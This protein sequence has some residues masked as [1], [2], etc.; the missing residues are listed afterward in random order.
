MIVDV[1]ICEKCRVIVECTPESKDGKPTHPTKC[2]EC[3]ERMMVFKDVE[4]GV[5][6]LK[7]SLKKYA[8][9]SMTDPTSKG[10]LTILAE[11]KKRRASS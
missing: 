1:Q 2:P 5:S 6:E 8:Y 9:Y 4:T 3:G 11:V 7:Q 10:G